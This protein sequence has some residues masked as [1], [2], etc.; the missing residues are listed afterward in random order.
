M[1]DAGGGIPVYRTAST[2]KSAAFVS[3]LVVMSAAPALAGTPAAFCRR[4]GTDDTTRP[5]PEALVPAVNAAFGMRMP[6]RKAVDTTV[7]RCAGG[8]V[9]VCTVGANLPCGKANTNRAPSTGVVRWCRDNPDASVVPAVATGHDTIYQWRCHAGAPQ[10]VR[11]T[12]HVDPRGFV[13]EFWKA[14]P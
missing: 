9:M 7:F 2:A 13:A 4:V 5:I 3:L 6:A 8:R 14:L 1:T 11:Q 10:F 12:H